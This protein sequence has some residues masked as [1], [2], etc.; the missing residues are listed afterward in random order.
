MTCPSCSAT[1]CKSFLA[2][3]LGASS[4]NCDQSL[5]SSSA[6]LPTSSIYK[7]LCQPFTQYQLFPVPAT[8]FSLLCLTRER[9]HRP[10]Q[11][12]AMG[13]GLE[14]TFGGC[15]PTIELGNLS[16]NAHRLCQTLKLFP[17]TPHGLHHGHPM[18]RTPVLFKVPAPLVKHHMIHT[19]LVNDLFI[20]LLFILEV[21]P[22]K[23]EFYSVSKHWYLF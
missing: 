18:H 14:G 15:S 8:F 21:E 5:L 22:S 20:L 6:S 11:L 23:W 16:T 12:G 7:E 9:E 3:C 19:H 2:P 10:G 1:L 13:A 4:K 17:Y